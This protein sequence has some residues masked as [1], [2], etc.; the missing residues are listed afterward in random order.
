MSA[1]TLLIRVAGG[2]IASDLGA[3]FQI[4]ADDDI[5]GGCAVAVGLL[6]AAIAAVETR[7]H[8]LAAGS[9]RR[10]GVDQRL[11]LGAPFLAFVV[12]ANAAQE[13]QRAEDFRQSLQVAIVGGRLILHA[14]LRRR[15]RRLRRQFGRGGPRGAPVWRAPPTPAVAPTVIAPELRLRR[16]YGETQRERD[17][18]HDAKFAHRRQ[19]NAD[20]THGKPHPNLMQTSCKP[21]DLGNWRVSAMRSAAAAMISAS[22]SVVFKPVSSSSLRQC[23]SASS[24]LSAISPP[25]QRAA[26]G[27]MTKWRST[28]PASSRAIASRKP[29]SA[30]GAISRPV[31]SR[32]SRMIAPSRVSPSSTPP[33]GSV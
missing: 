4:A 5:G 12:V 33:P 32:T 9:A 27:R 14:R 1:G 19:H 29:T 6:K 10:F 28:R 7:H 25:T 2:D 23:A 26:K 31:S 11:G 15:C 24:S 8:L 22:P 18:W 21:H 30:N 20:E 16:R 17:G 13:M 3:F